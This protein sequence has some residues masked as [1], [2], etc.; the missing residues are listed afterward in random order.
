MTFAVDPDS[1][2]IRCMEILEKKGVADGFKASCRQCPKG[3]RIV[4]TRRVYVQ[5]VP[6]SKPTESSTT[7]KRID[8]KDRNSTEERDKAI[9]KDVDNELG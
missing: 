3:V 7:H 1:D 6:L 9:F 2:C 8:E 5:T 4:G